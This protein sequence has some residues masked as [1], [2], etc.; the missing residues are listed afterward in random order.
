MK[1]LL[2][3][4]LCFTLCLTSISTT[5]I[6]AN[7]TISTAYDFTG[8]LN[9]KDWNDPEKSLPFDQKVKMCNIPEETLK[10]MSTEALVE[11]TLTHPLFIIVY[12]HDSV[13][14]GFELLLKYSNIFQELIRRKNV[15]IV[16]LK[17]YK[18]TNILGALKAKGKDAEISTFE[19]AYVEILLAQETINKNL[20]SNEL[21]KL[22]KEVA[23]KHKEKKENQNVFGLTTSTFYDI[24]SEQQNADNNQIE[25]KF[26]SKGYTITTP[27][28][29]KVSV[30]KRGEELTSFEKKNI[31]ANVRKAYPNVKYLREATTNYNCHSYAWYSSSSSNKYWMNN[32]MPYMTD[33][34]YIYRGYSK[35]SIGDKVYYSVSGGKHSG[36]VTGR[37]S[38]PIG[39][40]AYKIVTVT[41][42]WGKTGLYKHNAENCPYY[43]SGLALKFYYR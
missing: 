7:S 42:K 14:E 4:V 8:L 40:N 28:G 38:G 43:S 13:Q 18:D 3:L 39:P 31:Q 10:A 41:S 33:K 26:L 6:Y 9:S 27:N 23:K 36:R 25:I 17:K 22:D 21:K 12:T 5:N 30:K 29:S 16:L 11:T 20:N 1:K 24:L 35:A 2:Y 34:S 37:A 32:P 15:G 19:L